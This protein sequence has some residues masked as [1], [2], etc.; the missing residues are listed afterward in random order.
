MRTCAWLAAGGILLFAVSGH[1]GF[2]NLRV[3]GL[4]LL[5]RGAAGYWLALGPDRRA[6]CVRRL[7]TAAI[8]FEEF[9]ARLT[10]YGGS[11]VSL[12]DL[13]SAEAKENGQ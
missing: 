9:T 1:P 11:R 3:L 13:M 8:E 10:S 5:A 12:D 6:R 7:R 2:L 4:I